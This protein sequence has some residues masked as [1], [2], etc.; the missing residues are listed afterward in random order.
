MGW[1][2]VSSRPEAVLRLAIGV[3]RL[4]AEIDVDLATAEICRR[5]H[6][7]AIARFTRTAAAEAIA[8][9]RETFSLEL[10]LNEGNAPVWQ[11]TT[12]ISALCRARPFS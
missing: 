10:L 11:A 7:C 2:P 4:N 1:P 5:Y 9:R 12:G 6:W 8:P 3:R